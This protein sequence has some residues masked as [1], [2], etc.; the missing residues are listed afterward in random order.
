MYSK[1]C[2]TKLDLLSYIATRVG[3]KVTCEGL[4]F[5][6]LHR[7]CNCSQCITGQK[8]TTRRKIQPVVWDK[9]SQGQGSS[10]ST[11]GAGATGRG[12]KIKRGDPP[13]RG[14]Y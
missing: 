7:Y 8:A 9:G 5:A 10:S 3:Q 4:Y 13:R 6:Y 12:A 11:A 14:K 2:P 1:T